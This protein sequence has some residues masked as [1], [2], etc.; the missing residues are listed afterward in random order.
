[1]DL[2]NGGI[3]FFR[4]ALLRYPARSYRLICLAICLWKCFGA[5][6]GL[7]LKVMWTTGCNYC[8]IEM[9]LVALNTFLRWAAVVVT[10]TLFSD[11]RKVEIRALGGR[12]VNAVGGEIFPRIRE[13]NWLI[14]LL[15]KGTRSGHAFER[16]CSFERSAFA[17][18][19][20]SF[21]QHFNYSVALRTV[22]LCKVAQS[23][24]PLG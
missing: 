23:F 6:C 11:R 12:P 15:N 19:K 20:T 8:K 22:R 21:G 4:K 1:M 3:I 17:I 14:A 24:H 18:H 16:I 10:E 7:S 5:H 9:V 13:G 2:E